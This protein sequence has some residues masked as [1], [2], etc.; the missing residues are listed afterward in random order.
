MKFG[1]IQSIITENY[2]DFKKVE[3][4]DMVRPLDYA[5]WMK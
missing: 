3:K 5:K 2:K 4:L 1:E